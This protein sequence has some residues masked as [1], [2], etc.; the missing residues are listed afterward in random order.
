MAPEVAAALIAAAASLVLGI[1][2]LR[3]LAGL[4]K[5]KADLADEAMVH[6]ALIDY[7]YDARRRLYIS[8]YRVASMLQGSPAHEGCGGSA[9]ACRA[10]MLALLR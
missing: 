3:R 4:E 6:K 5:L 7:Q 10:G 8:A 9:A 1:Y 2:N